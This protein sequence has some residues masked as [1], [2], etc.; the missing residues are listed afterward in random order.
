MIDVPGKDSMTKQA[1]CMQSVWTNDQLPRIT[2][3]EGP[4][5]TSAHVRKDVVRSVGWQDSILSLAGVG[6]SALNAPPFPEILV[7]TLRCKILPPF[8][9]VLLDVVTHASEAAV[10]GVQLC[11]RHKRVLEATPAP[12]F[13]QER[14]H[15]HN[16]LLL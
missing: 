1:A 3:S 14:P 4:Y 7:A 6:T 10:A 9:W 11:C 16:T 5:V 13:R 2:G 8:C 15:G 12:N